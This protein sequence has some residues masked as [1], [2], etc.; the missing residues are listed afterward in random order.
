MQVVA[1]AM[2]KAS[3]KVLK[4]VAQLLPLPLRAMLLSTYTT[5]GKGLYAS[6]APISTVVLK[7]LFAPVMSVVMPAGMRAL[8]PASMPGDEAQWSNA[9]PSS[10]V[11][12]IPSAP[13]G[14]EGLINKGAALILPVPGYTPDACCISL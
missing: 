11:P 1:L 2:D 6:Y 9:S 10:A 4:A 7:I 13:A 5:E 14:S 12:K 3:D 8:L